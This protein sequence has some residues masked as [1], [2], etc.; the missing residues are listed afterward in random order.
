M[1]IITYERRYQFSL[2]LLD[3]SD[4]QWY[5]D[6]IMP[7]PLLTSQPLT[8]TK[9]PWKKWF[10]SILQGQGGEHSPD[11][12]QPT[13][14]EIINNKTMVNSIQLIRLGGD[15]MAVTQMQGYCT[16]RGA[17]NMVSHTHC[18]G[19]ATV[20]PP[21]WDCHKKYFTQVINPTMMSRFETSH[22]GQKSQTN[23]IV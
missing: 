9:D 10:S 18:M 17:N 15:S 1:K 19:A 2:F 21:D 23:K 13:G 11:L 14:V 4:L 3:W 16:L 12:A 6:V 5:D 20:K 7:C 22:K 8:C